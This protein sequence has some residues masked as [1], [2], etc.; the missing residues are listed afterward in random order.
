MTEMKVAVIEVNV[1]IR[2]SQEYIGSPDLI[3]RAIEMINA[4]NPIPNKVQIRIS[5]SLIM[6]PS[7][8]FSIQI[9][10]RLYE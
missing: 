1:P 10:Y 4:K 8:I 5:D 2:A 3:S 9:P 6:S 7:A